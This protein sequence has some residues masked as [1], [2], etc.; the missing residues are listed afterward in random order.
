M[1]ADR[2][3][4]TIA[5]S[6]ASGRQT[7]VNHIGGGRGGSG[8][9]GHGNGTGG[10]GGHGMGPSL[11][12]DISVGHLTMH[13]NVHGDDDF[14]GRRRYRQAAVG[15]DPLPDS[16][17]GPYIHQNIHQHG[18]R[19][20]DILHYAVALEAIHNSAESY[21]QPRCHPETRIEML[22][23]LRDWALDTDPET[24][25]LWLYGPAGAG[26]SAIMQTLA[27]QLKNAGVLGGTFF[28]KR[29]HATR[30]NAKTLFATIAYQLALSVPSLRTPISQIVENDRSIVGLLI[31]VQ[32]QNLISEPCRLHKNLDPIV[33]L[34]DGLDE[35]EG[36][37]IQVEILRIIL[38]S[39]SQD[40][41]PLRF[42]I[43]SRPEPH[44]RQVFDSSSSH[45][46]SFN[47]E[48]SFHD[49]RNYLRDELSRIHRDHL[50]MQNI[51]S[52]WP[53]H[54]VLEELV[55]KSSGYFIY[56][57]TII[58]FI[59][60]EN[61]HPPQRLAM[62]QDASS[63]GSASP[64]E[65]LDQLYLTILASARGQ[66]E[67]I[68]IICAI[69][70]FR[71]VPRSIDQLFGFAQGET[72]LILRGLHSV[73]N[74][75]QD[76]EHEIL[77]HHASFLD[78]LKHPDRSGIFCVSTINCRIGLARSLLQ[79]YAGPVQR[80]EIHLLSNLVHFIISLPPSDAVAQLFPLIG[81][82][83]PDFVFD[84]YWKN[85]NSPASIISSLKNMRSPPTDVIELWEDYAFMYSIATMEYGGAILSVKRIISPT[86]ELVRIL[87]GLGFLHC[88]LWELP[89]TLDLTWTDLRIT[90]CS[91]R[92]KL[93]GN[94]H[95]L[96]I[97]QPQADHAGVAR[98]LAL[99]LI[100]KMIKNYI[101]TDGGVNLTACRDPVF[102]YNSR[103]F[104]HDLEAYAEAQ[105]VSIVQRDNR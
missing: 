16:H 87:V 42:I 1:P 62:V 12:F 51:S 31:E 52:P 41:S 101:A 3:R 23:D 91:L 60:D 97:H 76:E 90:L 20:I 14:G 25:V 33:I 18:D 22:E 102:L 5:Q 54:H 40:P 38:Q 61:Y 73:L 29:G 17:L 93:V 75:P 103:W 28:F 63:T 105:M 24:T 96:P 30:G 35:C 48:Q 21:P 71:L 67:L 66:S 100:C 19:G 6:R 36:H 64:F 55:R 43:A 79:F 77:S 47:V 74:I 8:G 13:N 27:S 2:L 15:S 9:D 88:R 70:N 37:N 50:T 83:N 104:L 59:G 10:S 94:E 85:N 57:S 44:I 89:T 4:S 56:A 92:P 69:V 86:P 98:D 49:V 7:M 84:R 65:A 39:S 58:K 68:Q 11:S 78:F 32:M 80:N 46:C 45:Y 82:V 81:S 34:I 95:V 99:Q 26:K 53:I 72:R